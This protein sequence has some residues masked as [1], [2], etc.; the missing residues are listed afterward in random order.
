MTRRDDALVATI[1]LVEDSRSLI[2]ATQLLRV[3]ANLLSAAFFA[4]LGND[5]GS[6]HVCI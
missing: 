3:I 5:A 2:S 1:A 4:T 6:L